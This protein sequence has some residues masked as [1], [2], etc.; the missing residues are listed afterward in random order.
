[1]KKTIFILSALL[2]LAACDS[3]RTETYQDDLVMALEDGSQDSLY[4]SVS[5]E[6]V[7]AGLKAQARD[8]INST[9]V[10]QVFDLEGGN[11]TLEES[12]IRYR[13]N[14][15][16]EYMNENAVLESGVRT[17]EDRMVGS[18]QDNYKNWKNYLI[19]YFSYR[20]SAH[21]IQTLT[22]IVFDADSGK[23]LSEPDFF[24]D[25]YEEPVTALIQEAIRTS[26][27]A[28]SPELL[29]LV[30]LAEVTPNGNLSVSEAGMEWFFQPFEVGPYAL[31]IVSAPVSWNQLKP[32]LK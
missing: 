23:Q 2:L 11:G 10:A 27:E 1:M 9:I 24:A 17:W 25:G 20:G 16:D 15:I 4:F 32:Y 7:A 31:G 22:H 30:D 18:F 13:E 8:Q 3:F 29:E 5:V 28:E 21:G 14:L 26:L 19:S 6:Y 12:A